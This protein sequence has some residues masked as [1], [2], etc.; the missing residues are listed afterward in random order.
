MSK[1]FC[2]YVFLN[3]DNASDWHLRENSLD[4]FQKI[5]K[6]TKAHL[7]SIRDWVPTPTEVLGHIAIESHDSHEFLKRVSERGSN[8]TTEELAAQ[9]FFA[10]VPTA[11]HFSQVIAHVVDFYLDDDKRKERDEIVKL[12]SVLG[13]NE[14]VGKVMDYVR[15]ALRESHHQSI[16]CYAT[17]KDLP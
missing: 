16:S 4:A 12:A 17:A 2:S 5:S 10:L 3:F 8:F 7:D 1:D 13:D 6:V 14:A 9:V 11:A 15:E